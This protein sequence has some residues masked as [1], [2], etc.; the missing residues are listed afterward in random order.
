MVDHE[1]LNSNWQRSTF[2]HTER[3]SGLPNLSTSS[4]AL[5]YLFRVL[6]QFYFNNHLKAIIWTLQFY[7]KL[8]KLPAI[9]WTIASLIG[10]VRV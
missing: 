1:L 4:L 3:F 2:T 8:V 7:D 6:L 5:L 9:E 10:F